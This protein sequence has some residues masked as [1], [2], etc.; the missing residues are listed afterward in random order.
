MTVPQRLR[1]W[2]KSADSMAASGLKTNILGLT[3]KSWKK[4]L[5]V[6][7]AAQIED[8]KQRAGKTHQASAE[9][10]EMLKR[11]FWAFQIDLP[12]LGAVAVYRGIHFTKDWNVKWGRTV[13]QE[14][15]REFESVKAEGSYSSAS[16]GIGER[17]GGSG[18]K[19]PQPTWSPRIGS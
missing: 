9:L 4:S 10:K 1:L 13:G 14:S 18:E 8:P 6:E 2:K 17:P 15:A 16:M 5:A 19:R 11:L 3:E 12:E 7:Q